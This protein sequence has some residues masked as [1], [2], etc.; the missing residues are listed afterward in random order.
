MKALAIVLVLFGSRF[1]TSAW[2][3]NVQDGDIGWQ[4]WLGATILRQHRIPSH[5]G[6]ETFTAIG[7]PWV[8]QEWLLGIF[9]AFV[10]PFHG[11]WMLAVLSALCA[12]F[13]LFI[14][15]VRAYRRGAT[16]A[17]TAICT[18]AVGLA[19]IMSFGVR[20]QVLAWPFL[21]LF[22]L[23]LELEGPLAWLT[24]P[25]AII[26]SN[27]HASAMLAPALALAAAVGVALEERRWDRRL[28]QSM[29]LVPALAISICVNPLTWHLPVYAISLFGSPIRDV[30]S[31]WQPGNIANLWFAL[32]A[33]TLLLAA[34]ALG[35][36][37]PRDRWRDGILF[38]AVLF[39][40]F[41]AMR[42]ATVFAIVIAPLVAA[43]ITEVLRLPPPEP[44]GPR[45]RA[46]GWGVVAVAVLAAGILVFKL[47]TNSQIVST[48]L[49]KNAIA[50]LERTPG[51][52]HLLC[53]DFA[54]CG[55]ALGSKNVQTFL[56]GRCDP[57]PLS[58]WRDY[59][60][61]AFLESD[62]QRRLENSRVNAIVVKKT[63]PLGQALPLLPQWKKLYGDKTYVVFV[64]A[65]PRS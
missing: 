63:D 44:E 27:L 18:A 22:V 19:M 52:H 55:D 41:S 24:I 23:L 5:L 8:P 54:W 45:E 50:A 43:R 14:V 1:L 57:F 9:L 4:R 17:V 32:G 37:V 49:P 42:N 7:S 47:L 40:L 15:G 61:I 60:A 59:K 36:A 53:G 46:A 29:L 16:A 3:E 34:C 25:T 33:C 31:E 26:W 30:I 21:A 20:A 12:V 13:T 62:W 28:V 2:F 6:A 10:Q 38:A 35:V 65:T 48:T 39:L 64:R 51:T 58:V 11:F 56:D